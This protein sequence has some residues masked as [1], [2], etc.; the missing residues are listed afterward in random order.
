MTKFKNNRVLLLLYAFAYGFIMLSLDGIRPYEISEYHRHQAE[1]LLNGNLYLSDSLYALQPGLVWYNGH[2][3]QVWGLGIGLWLLP[4][5]ATW[6]L[7]SHQPIPDRIVLGLAFALLAFFSASTGLRLIKDGKTRI[8]FAV[9]CFIVLCPALWT[10][11]RASQE[12]FEETILYSIILSLAILVALIR[13]GAFSSRPDHFMCSALGSF[14]IWVRPTH[15]AYGLSAVLISSI[16]AWNS[17]RSLKESISG[18]MLWLASFIILCWANGVR[19]G[20]PSEFGHHL[21]ISSGN[22]MY[23]T[24]F[25]NPFRTASA[26]QAT[27]ELAGL[28]FLSD[29]RGVNAFAGGLFPGQTSIVR[30]RRLDLSAFDFAWA[31]V[32]ITAV[33]LGVVWLIRRKARYAATSK[34]SE[35]SLIFAISAW[36]T[37]SFATLFSF[38]LYYPTIASRYLFD[39]SPALM[40]FAIL[41]PALFSPSLTKYTIPLLAA[42]CIY[43]IAS[44]KI[45]V[46]DQLPPTPVGPAMQDVRTPTLESFNGVYT[47][48]QH[49]SATRIAG[50]GFGWD[51]RSGIAEDVISLAVD[52]PTFVQLR[53]SE[54]RP[55][56][57]EIWGTDTYRAQI[58]GVSLPLRDV[59]RDKNML[60]VT[61]DVPV[62][63]R[64]RTEFLFLC[65]SE[66]YDEDDRM[67]ERYLFSVSWR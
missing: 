17:R 14:A 5:G 1:A 28:L 33:I 60:N 31:V 39:F 48:D 6:R 15:G 59:T 35:A 65:F 20:A 62:Q 32:C 19:F 44:S 42:W 46:Q 52:K 30:W 11:E 34:G 8:G 45:P 56:N 64:M 25:G 9:M 40:G 37:V 53:V 63:L 3:Q 29:P 47:V 2:V 24:R 38:Y 49:P 4:F 7:F 55:Q 18:V 23:L 41:I 26:F 66:T 10:L 13:M 21:T 50:N 27:R 12:V 61:F 51:S 43:E 16:I 58:A 57:G 36:S 22:M 67:S 54:R